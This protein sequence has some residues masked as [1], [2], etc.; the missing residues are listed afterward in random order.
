M[1]KQWEADVEITQELAARLIDRQFPFL[2]PARV[3]PFGV[4][5]DVSAAAGDGMRRV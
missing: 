1:P 3:E 5:W 4:G 2:A